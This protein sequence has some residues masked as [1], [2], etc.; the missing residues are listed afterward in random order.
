MTLKI[1]DI[2]S[3][4]PGV[5]IG[6]K[7]RPSV[8]VKYHKMNREAKRYIKELVQSLIEAFY[9]GKEEIKSPN[10]TVVLNLNINNVKAEARNTN[11]I[12]INVQLKEVL[13]ELFRWLD[14]IANP[15]S[16]YSK[17]VPRYIKSDA[18]RYRAKIAKLLSQE[19]N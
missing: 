15:V 8:Y 5:V 13:E 16:G 2:D 4:T 1:E 17:D 6:F 3:D 9:E 19:V 18:A 14:V 11:N 10:K 12:T 7:V